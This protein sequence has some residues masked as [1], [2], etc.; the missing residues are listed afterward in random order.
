M[1]G[2]REFVCVSASE[3]LGSTGARVYLVLSPVF[4]TLVNQT[5]QICMTQ[6][7]MSQVQFFECI[8]YPAWQEK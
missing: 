8:F 2:G 6:I 1:R 7:E 5:K 3:K 4:T